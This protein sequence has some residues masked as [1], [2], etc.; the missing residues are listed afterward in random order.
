LFKESFSEEIVKLIFPQLKHLERL[1][2]LN[3]SA[4]KKLNEVDF[5]FLISLM[6]IDETDNIDYF[7]Y[8]FNIS[9]A[10]KKR[11]L[12]IKRFYNEINNEN[13]F[14]EKNLW[15]IFYYNGKQSLKDLLYFKIFLSKNVNKKF[16]NLI[17]FF[18]NKEVPI[19]P[20]KGENIINKYNL[21]EG[22][23]LGVKLKKI[24]E[25]WVN[26]NFKISEKEI[27]QLIE[28]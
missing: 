8:K 1:K 21:S 14:S 12:F 4:E 10:D 6:I 27:T 15:K 19:F 9:N 3:K 23:F 22:K 17:D 7:L 16:N 2:K 28:N 25:K 26:N 18:E 11:I 20:I 13:F 24:E 5:T